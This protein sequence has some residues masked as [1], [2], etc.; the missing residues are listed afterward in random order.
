MRRFKNR[1]ARFVVDIGTRRDTDPA[2]LRGQRIRQI[3]P[4]QIHRGQYFE[5][6]R[7]Q[8]GLLETIVTDNIID[9]DF[10]STFRIS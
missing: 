8:Q 4:I 3:I 1:L 7:M 6:V 5:M 2:N 10:A 9:N